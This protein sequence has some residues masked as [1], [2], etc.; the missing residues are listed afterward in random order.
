MIITL[1]GTVTQ[2]M[3][4][5]I[6]L[7]VSGIGYQVFVS[8]T[9]LD[10]LSIDTNVKLWTYEHLRED[11]R[12]LYGFLLPSEHRLFMRI[13]DIS[14][15]GPKMA[16]HILALGSVADIEKRIEA[17]DADYLTLAHGVGKKTAQKIVL[18]LRGKLSFEDDGDA[19][20]ISA[21]MQLG[22]SKEKARNA[23]ALAPSSSSASLE[24]RL[25]SAL[26]KL[27]KSA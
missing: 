9:T 24:E 14:G 1:S 6:V 4:D 11:A 27:G 3:K 15:I 10:N 26:Q 19:D 22:Y 16:L 2:K 5:F 20:M 7:E 17:G 23:I 18:E 25:R 12:D 8:G 13:V 21:L